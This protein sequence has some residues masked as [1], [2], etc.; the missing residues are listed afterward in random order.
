LRGSAPFKPLLRVV[1]G[2][3]TTLRDTF[4]TAHTQTLFLSHLFSV[5]AAEL[6]NDLFAHASLCTMAVAQRV[7]GLRAALLDWIEK[8]HLPRS[9]MYV[10][11]KLRLRQRTLRWLFALV[12][13]VSAC[14]LLTCDSRRNSLAPLSQAAEVLVS[15]KQ[16]YVFFAPFVALY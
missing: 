10:I 16:K 8:R 11:K 6:L 12:E 9:V 15:N 7:L 14:T 4:A 5:L 1:R 13:T 2:A 3:L